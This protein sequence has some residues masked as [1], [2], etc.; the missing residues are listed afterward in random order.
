MHFYLEFL[1]NLHCILCINLPFHAI[2]KYMYF[3]NNR[4][5]EAN[6]KCHIRLQP[7][8]LRTH[9]TNLDMSCS[10]DI[11]RWFLE[12]KGEN[13]FFPPKVRFL[14]NMPL[15]NKSRKRQ[16]SG[17]CL[18]L[19]VKIE[20]ILFPGGSF[21]HQRGFPFYKAWNPPHFSV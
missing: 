4:E 12:F 7:I 5:F 20:W 13:N 1:D 14:E 2:K 19:N 10:G 18:T 3:K 6:K 15:W 16:F 17:N 11:Y 21:S 9:S 8:K